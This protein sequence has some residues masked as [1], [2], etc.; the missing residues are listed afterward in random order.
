MWYFGE[1]YSLQRQ[2]RQQLALDTEEKRINEFF[3]S[4][5]ATTGSM[6]FLTSGV[7][8]LADVTESLVVKTV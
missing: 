7:N 5:V 6:T 3:T 1:S 8:I 4:G 2:V